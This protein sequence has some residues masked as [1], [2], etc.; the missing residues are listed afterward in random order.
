MASFSLSP[1][2]IRGGYVQ[3][4]GLFILILKNIDEIN[5][6]I[7]FCFLLKYYLISLKDKTRNIYSYLFTILNSIY[8]IIS[9]DIVTK[10]IEV[11]SSLGLARP[12]K[13][14]PLFVILLRVTFFQLTGFI[15]IFNFLHCLR[16]VQ[17]RVIMWL[18]QAQFLETAR[19]FY[20]WILKW[21]F[22]WIWS[23]L[24]M[25]QTVTITRRVC[26]GLLS[27][28]IDFLFLIGKFSTAI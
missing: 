17:E 28:L 14:S 22:G 24:A 11:H 18:F 12:G 1:I 6:W 20:F 15:S 27:L 23:L 19:V 4:R 21:I 9:M 13:P 3:K 2:G 5:F 7:I 8:S 16:I 26:E 10:F 25:C